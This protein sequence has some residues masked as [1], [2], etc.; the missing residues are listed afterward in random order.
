MEPVPNAHRIGNPWGLELTGLGYQYGGIKV[1]KYLY[2]GKELQGDHGL[3]TFDFHWRVYD[4][5]IG[6]TFQLDPKA[7]KFYNLS[8][9]SWAAG[10][11]L[12]YI[13]PDGR[14]II[15]TDGKPV[16]YQMVN[17]QVIW[18]KNA[19]ADVQRVGNSMLQTSKGTSRLDAM[20]GSDTRVN[21]KVSNEIRIS[22]N[23]ETGKTIVRY[24]ETKINQFEE[25]KDGTYS[26]KEST[27]TIFEGTIKTIVNQKQQL[28]GDAGEKQQI[29]VESS[30]GAVA[31]HESIHAVDSEN[32]NQNIQNQLHGKN[33][34]VEKKANE[35]EKQV[36]S[37]LLRRKNEN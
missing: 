14:E 4:P 15:G 20:I 35:V 11:P 27:I 18:S 25:N 3:N 22:K 28:S 36:Q 21:I 19:S 12:K 31:A 17:G 33:H 32:V 10:N 37:E 13:D 5:V 1:N 7:D 16:T 30:I 24:G 2:Q 9:Y 26:A 23:P 34:D 8:P 29:G 6:R